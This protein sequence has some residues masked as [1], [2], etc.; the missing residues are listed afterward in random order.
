[1][2]TLQIQD[3]F[4]PYYDGRKDRFA[5]LDPRAVERA[6]EA[7]DRIEQDRR[8]QGRPKVEDRDRAA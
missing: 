2:D 4:E 8:A 7:R 6:K 3:A 1:M 5:R